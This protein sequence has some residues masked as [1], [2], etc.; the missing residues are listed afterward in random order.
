[1]KKMLPLLAA[2]F[3]TSPALAAPEVGKVAPDFSGISADGKTVKLSD[4]AGK[5]V[6][7]EWS[8]PGCPFVKKFYNSEAM[9]KQQAAAKAK[10]VVWL[11]INSGA[12][13]N[14]GSLDATSSKALIAEQKIAS[15]AY[16]LDKEGAI[17]HL[18]GAKTTPHMFVID[19]KGV[20]AYAG[21]IDDKASTDSADIVGAT[22]YVDAALAALMAGKTPEVTN[23]QS[24]G[25]PVKY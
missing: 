22:N 14:Q 12:E 21:A 20:L 5:T 1:M 18:Y 15:A 6:V 4:Y 13:G 8:N 23:T 17:G 16:L 24:Y 25:C 9:Q 2:L 3:F 7:L 11:T 19:A 10:G